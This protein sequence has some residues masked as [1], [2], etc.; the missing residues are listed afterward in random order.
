MD[1]IRDNIGRFRDN[2]Q[3]FISTIAAHV[4]VSWYEVFE[5]LQLGF[6]L[7]Y[8]LSDGTLHWLKM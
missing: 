4:C 1:G 6:S 7:S 8:W 2:V 3:F 5:A